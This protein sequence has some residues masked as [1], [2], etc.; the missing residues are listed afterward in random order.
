MKKKK[1]ID[2]EEDDELDIYE[3]YDRLLEDDEIDAIEAG[4]MSGYRRAS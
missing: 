2:I 3:D 1:I 4:F